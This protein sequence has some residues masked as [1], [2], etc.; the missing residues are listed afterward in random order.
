M[1]GIKPEDQAGLVI[2]RSLTQLLAYLPEQGPIVY[3]IKLED[4]VRV[5]RGTKANL[6]AGM[7]TAKTRGG[8]V[9]ACHLHL[10]SACTGIC[11]CARNTT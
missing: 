1:H 8:K 10:K 9:R 4:R 3:G 2:D 6:S 7:M 5:R 11:D